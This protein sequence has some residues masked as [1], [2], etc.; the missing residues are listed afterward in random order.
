MRFRSFRRLYA[1]DFFVAAAWA[2]LLATTTTWQT[3]CP[4]LYEQYAVLASTEPFTL[5]FPRREQ[6]FLRATGPLMILFN[7]CLWSI[8]MSFLVFFWRLGSKLAHRRR[9]WAVFI[10]TALS[11]L[12]CIADTEF[13]CSFGS[14]EFIV[15]EFAS[16]PLS[17]IA[18]TD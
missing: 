2:M 18:N 8:K 14:L 17:L 10:I 4:L 3:V 6:K 13:R 7:S 11:W 15:G 9:W 16:A 12:A 5:A 1:D